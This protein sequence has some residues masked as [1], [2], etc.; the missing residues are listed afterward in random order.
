MGEKEAEKGAEGIRGFFQ[1]KINDLDDATY[2]LPPEEIKKD[3]S[4]ATIK[5]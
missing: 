4:D 1:K 2:I 3:S 5:L